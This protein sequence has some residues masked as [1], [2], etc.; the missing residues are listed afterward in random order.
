MHTWLGEHERMRRA[1]G[2]VGEVNARS[3]KRGLSHT[4]KSFNLN[5]NFKFRT[6]ILVNRNL[7]S[8]P[9]CELRN[10]I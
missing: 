5:L 1:C 7:K 8:R 10:A 6:V 3:P 9:I 4:P 2:L